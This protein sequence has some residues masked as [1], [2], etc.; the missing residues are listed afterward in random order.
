MKKLKK[1][2]FI[3]TIILT[4]VFTINVFA[5]SVPYNW[6][7]GEETVNTTNKDNTASLEKIDKK[8]TLKLNNYKGSGLKLNCYGT[9]Q[10]GIEFVIDLEG[11]NEITDNSIGIEF[12]YNGKIEFTGEGSLKINAPKPIGYEE[13]TDTMIINPKENIYTDKIEKEE[14]KE[15][16]VEEVKEDEEEKQLISPKEETKETKIKPNN[17]KNT[18]I[19]IIIGLIGLLFVVIIISAIIKN[20]RKF[21]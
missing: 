20:K 8:V 21:R 6:I 18:A 16:T 7:V 11:E 4:S 19:Y 9:G 2:L 3:I 5:A 1:L 13:Y 15:E 12:N 17:D 14:P 10:E